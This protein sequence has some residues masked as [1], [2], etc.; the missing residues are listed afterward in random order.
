MNFLDWVVKMK[1]KQK[2]FLLSILTA[3]ISGSLIFFSSYLLYQR[4]LKQKVQHYNYS[5]IGQIVKNIDAYFQQL[6]NIAY[7]VA[8]N[9]DLQTYITASNKSAYDSIQQDKFITNAL[10][11]YYHSQSNVQMCLFLENDERSFFT[12]NS[13]INSN[14]KF[15]EDEWYRKITKSNSE[16]LLL[17]NN[18]QKYYEVSERKPVISV[19][20]K[21]TPYYSTRPI[22]YMIID[23][24]YEQL[25]KFFQTKYVDVK[26]TTILTGNHEV[27]YSIPDN[28]FKHGNR[29]VF[30][31]NQALGFFDQRFGEEEYMVIYGTSAYTG[32]R[33]V[34]IVSYVDLL[35]ELS[36]TRYHYLLISALVLVITMIT[37]YGFASLLTQPIHKLKK[38]MVKVKSG[39]FD[40]TV[41]TSSRDELGM[42]VDDFNSMVQQIDDLMLKNQ[43]SEI[44]KREAQLKAL[45][46]QINPH[47]LYNT[48]EMII[49]ASS[50]NDGERVILICK[51]LG[52]MLRYNLNFH[53]VESI[54]AE[55]NQIRNYLYIMEQRFEGKFQSVFDI[56]SEALGNKTIKFTLQPFVEN[57]ILHGFRDTLQGGLL[58]IAIQKWDQFVHISIFD[59][60]KGFTEAELQAT[61]DRMQTSIQN[62]LENLDTNSQLGILNVYLRLKLLF[63]DQCQFN[64]ISQPYNSTE[65]KITIPAMG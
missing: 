42:L 6:Q 8:Y 33:I 60:G 34:N 25:E 32:W 53:K 47:F 21:I 11:Y 16:K 4:S 43:A 50:D 10:R 48:L 29:M 26:N 7:S 57:A 9:P 37:S 45:Q 19:V 61:Q 56:D 30:P 52:K 58:K 5:I 59:N 13:N 31:R 20:Y 2:T 46:Q 51:S 38:A 54:G 3:F 49:G 14:Y 28:F 63:G 40:F 35:R 15:K 24:D 12:I 55:V 65:I 62:I 64:I 41:S 36:A 27:I 23:I 44:L 17:L 18:P 22:A 39:D 1:I